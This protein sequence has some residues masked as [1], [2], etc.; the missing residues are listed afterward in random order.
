MFGIAADISLRILAAAA[1]VGLVL[2]VFRV[3]SGAARHAAWS[4]VLLAM[5][6]M[7]VLTTIVPRVEVPVPSTLA[8]DFG[9][10]AGEPAP[11][12]AVV[13][14]IDSELAAVETS[15]ASTGAAP[16]AQP[17][18]A[19]FP[20]DWRA[21]ALALYGAGVLFFFVR[22][23]GG[24]L[25]ARRLV[26][27]ATRV[28]SENRA[29]VYESAAI[30]TPLTTGV[31]SPSVLLP[32]AWR[33]WP[34]DK[35]QA[36]LAHEN[37]H[38][39]RRDALVAFLAHANRAI[40]WFHPLAW[41]LERTL[42]VTAEHACDETAARQVGQPRRYAE[43]LLDMAEAVRARGHRVSWQTIGVDGSGLLGTRIDR[44]L[45]GDAMARM[46][47]M[48]RAA[49]AVGCAAVLV[50]AIACRQQIAA[51]PLRPDPEVAE[52]LARQDARTKRFEAVRDMTPEQA[53]VLEA[54]IEKDP[55]DWDAREQLVTYYRAGREIPWAKKVPGLRRHALWLIEHHPGHTI[56]APP[57]SPQYD[58]EG[59]TAA[60]RLWDAHLK[61]QDVTPFLVYRAA[62]FFAPHDKPR[63][64]QLIL[65]GLSMDPDSA[66]LKARMPPNVGGYQWPSQ[67]ADLYASALVGSESMWG[68]YNDLR[69]HF[70][71]LKAPY[72]M[73]VRGK[74]DASTDARLIASVGARLTRPRGPMKDAALQEAHERLRDLGVSY[75][76]RAVELDPQLESAKASLYMATSREP[77]N[78]ADRLAN[79][80]HERYM[81]SEDITEYA[82]K[83]PARAK[84]EREAAT[85]D[86]HAVLD[87]AKPH[88]GDPAYSAAVM[89]AHHLLATDA[90][91][92]GDR[93]Q[94]VLHLRESVKVPTSDQIKY[95]PPSSWMRPVNRLLKEGERERVVEFLESYA[96]LTVR[97]R[98][99]LLD[100]ATAIREGRMPS[101]YQHMIYREGAPS[102]F[103]PR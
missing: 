70:D 37:A 4:A 95:A 93:D 39:A 86:A 56:T 34:E 42:A 92:Q 81:F 20:V 38:I 31:F 54:R 77:L 6:T 102:P 59:F 58:P 43:V 84:T 75:L 68:T 12:E 97:D 14:P 30:G 66:A 27:G 1:A 3:R 101:A 71:R 16:E 21:A 79:R 72:A 63:A 46:S 82:K 50:L 33:G 23:A 51:E 78:E 41:W 80:A 99:R 60:V 40:F 61:R 15:F 25:M 91:R 96:R 85:R 65:R 45:K 98:Q 7:P 87:M 13:T 5:L 76:R 94:A 36:V 10:I 24:W 90:L 35:L 55:N 103:K 53:D 89:T 28:A 49:V 62:R 18:P 74:L 17:A 22:L 2:V 44:L 19:R 32:L 47:G 64:E 9:A 100:D 29:P 26:A 73:E 8:L 52:R 69:T 67:L 88:A 57:L 83:D 11:Y 48:Q